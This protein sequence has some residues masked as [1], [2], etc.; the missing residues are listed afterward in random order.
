M[1]IE[2]I[3][4]V[5][6][7]AAATPVIIEHDGILVVRDDLFPGS[8]KERFLGAMFDGVHEVVYASP[9]EGGA[10][11]ALICSVFQNRL[12]KPRHGIPHGENTQ[13]PPYGARTNEQPEFY[14]L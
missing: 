8:T 2:I 7:I 11:S 12:D 13:P 4:I 14:C 9:A 10:Q 3:S 1:S 6:E 5:M